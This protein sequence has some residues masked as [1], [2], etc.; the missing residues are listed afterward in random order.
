VRR[1]LFLLTL[2]SA[3]SLSAAH[4]EVHFVSPLAGAQLYGATTLEVAS[5]TPNIDRVEFFVD[6]RM[7]GVARSAPF[8]VMYDFGESMTARTISAKL[9]SDHFTHVE[10]TQIETLSPGAAAAITV[11][12]VEVPF[13]GRFSSRPKPSDLTL[14]EDGVKQQIAE[15]RSE[16][17]DAHFVFVVDRSLSMSGTKLDAT[18]KG[19]DSLRKKLRSG[20]SA[21]LITFN[22]RVDAPVTLTRD[23]LSPRINA[24]G[25][26]S[27]RDALNSIAPK[28]RTYVIVISDGSDRNSLSKADTVLRALSRRNVSVHAVLLG[29]GNA[30]EL[31]DR[32]AATSGGIVLHS[33]ARKLNAALETIWN[34]INSRYLAVYQSSSAKPGWRSIELTARG[35]TIRSARKGYYAQ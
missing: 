29:E 22:H 13:R 7:A 26:T 14:R 18:L 6:G 31:L 30:G 3:L 19:V 16:R 32:L 34:E 12:L 15:V 35:T 11:D 1:S 21:S 33:D 17:G 27:L 25:G 24:S 28:E 20:D 23:T 4:G 9:Y 2:L 10:T 5:N 8:R